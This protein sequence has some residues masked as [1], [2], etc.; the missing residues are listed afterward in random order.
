[1]VACGYIDEV[2][3]AAKEKAKTRKVGAS[4]VSVFDYTNIDALVRAA[5][6]VAW[7]NVNDTD[8]CVNFDGSLS[9]N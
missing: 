9:T 7:N 4:T 6:E 5:T 1:M 2:V 8:R 3:T